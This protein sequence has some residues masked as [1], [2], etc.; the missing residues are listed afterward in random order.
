VRGV[1]TTT[2]GALA[3][4]LDSQGFTNEL[5]GDAE[6][7]LRGVNTLDDAVAGEI[8]FL[9]NPKYRQLA[10]RSM[11]S[12]LIVGRDEDL[13]FDIPV[14]K[15]ADPYAALTAATVH[16][17]GYRRHP[18]WGISAGATV[19]NSAHIGPGASIASGAT[20]EEDAVIGKNAVIYPGVYVGR[21]V[22]IGDDVVL[23]PNVTIYEDCRLGHRVTLHAG[24][25][26][27][28]DG[29]GY[30]PVEGKWFKIPQVGRVEV[31]D[32]VE[33]G[34]N[35]TIDRATLGTTRIGA[36]TKFSNLI[37]IGHGTKIG[38][39][40]M[41]VA[42][43]GIA[44]SAVIGRHVTIAG[45][46]GVVG[47]IQIGD[48]VQI[49][50]QAGVTESIEPGVTVLGAPAVP[51]NEAKRQMLLVQKLPEL[52]QRLKAMEEELAALRRAVESRQGSAASES[53]E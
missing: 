25:V 39:D 18:R 53:D 45:Q 32:D 31:G 28:E 26:I 35:C 42:H 1:A 22:R 40:C 41:F 9:T 2:L 23:Y 8:S 44:G 30:A 14:L 16:I 20:V 52:R 10:R 34:A 3:R 49:G 29:L 17:H 7:V 46:A 4:H 36:G 13:S 21:N 51:I 33:L 47:H 24:T 50:A 6:T 11:A 19:A 15:C 5:V 12:A 38:E 37:A 43:V 27:G 48:N